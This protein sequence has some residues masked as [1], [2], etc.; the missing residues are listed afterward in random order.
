MYSGKKNNLHRILFAG[1]AVSALLFLSACVPPP[2]MVTTTP[3][4]ELSAPLQN[5][6]QNLI[7][8]ERNQVSAALPTENALEVETL[9]IAVEQ[10]FAVEAAIAAAVTTPEYDE[11]FASYYA[12]RFNGRRTASGE[13]YDPELLSA[14]T[15]DYPMKSWIKVI[16][17]A[18][19]KEVNVRINDRTGKRKTPL[20][21]LSRA[22][23]KKLGFLGKGKIRVQVIPLLPTP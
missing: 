9:P 22:A 15:R 6:T 13:R 5:A 8:A 21:D 4:P 12:K 7:G 11:S 14:A 19:G 18:N 20:I 16:N 17:P 2:A 10:E 1:M 23:A 3:P